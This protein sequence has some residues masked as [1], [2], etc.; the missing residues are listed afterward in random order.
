[1]MDIKELLG[2]DF[3]D[4]GLP[5]TIDSVTDN[6][7]EMEAVHDAIGRAI[8]KD[9]GLLEGGQVDANEMIKDIAF[10]DDRTMQM[11]MYYASKNDAFMDR[12]K[13]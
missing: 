9:C 5:E 12:L 7:I 10:N 11:L 4:K 6:F 2:I 13:N 8:F 3:D 1:M